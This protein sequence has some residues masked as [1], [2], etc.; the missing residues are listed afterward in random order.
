MG[1]VCRNVPWRSLK[2]ILAVT[3]AFVGE[4]L[5]GCSKFEHGLGRV[6]EGG[7]P[8]IRGRSRLIAR[9]GCNY[10]PGA[11]SKEFVAE[12]RCSTSLIGGQDERWRME[13]VRKKIR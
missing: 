6:V 13:E 1:S 7:G 11:S 10:S 4:G 8:V 3:F 5:V 2:N 9:G 12:G